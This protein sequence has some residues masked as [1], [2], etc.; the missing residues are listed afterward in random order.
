[1]KIITQQERSAPQN[2]FS[3]GVY[4]LLFF[5]TWTLFVFFVSPW[6]KIHGVVA[7]NLVAPMM[8]VVIWTIPALLYLRYRDHVEPLAYLKM[9]GQLVNGALYGVGFSLLAIGIIVAKEYLLKRTLQFNVNFALDSWIGGVLLVGFTE[10]LLFRGFFLQK[11][12]E[13]TTFWRANLIATTL[14]LFSH[15]PGWLESHSFIAHLVSGGSY[16]F[17]FALIQGFVLKK[18]NSLWAC[19]IIH[20]I[21]N[22]MVFGFR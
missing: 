18:S 19:I 4:A 21:N 20:A 7:K 6:L 14:F 15:F 1:M 9:K 11:I 2:R 8:K 5:I 3:L 16:I 12:S 13:T 22:L 10:E 17:F